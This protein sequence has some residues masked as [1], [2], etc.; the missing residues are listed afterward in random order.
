MHQEKASTGIKPPRIS[1]TA[2][3]SGGRLGDRSTGPPCRRYPSAWPWVSL[4]FRSRWARVLYEIGQLWT[5]SACTP[6]H[7]TIRPAVVLTHVLLSGG[8]V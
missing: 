3:L 4:F 8:L 1:I 2:N 5:G 6:V 7:H